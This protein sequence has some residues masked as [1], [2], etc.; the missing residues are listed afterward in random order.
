MKVFCLK[1][2]K[3]SLEIL[4]FVIAYWKT[5]ITDRCF[6]F[7]YILDH[8]SRLCMLLKGTHTVHVLHHFLHLIYS[9]ADQ[10]TLQSH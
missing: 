9:H 3:I 5:Q 10:W 4:I 2:K 6:Y 8:I 7:T 1:L